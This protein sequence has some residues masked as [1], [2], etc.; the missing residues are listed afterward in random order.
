MTTAT[1]SRLGQINQAGDV[2]AMFLKVF[3]GEVLTAFEQKNIMMGRHQVRTITHGKSASFP[4]TGR[5]TARYHTPGEQVLGTKMSH[6]E[7]IITIDDLLLA[8]SFIA[9][10]DEA[11]NHYEVRSIY[12]GEMGNALANQMDKHI[13][14]VAILAARAANKIT[15]LPGGSI[16]GTNFSGAP[17]AANYATNGEHLAEALFLAAQTLDE[18]DVPED[19]RFCVVRPA[20]YYKLVTAVKN[21]NKDWGG[22]GT[23]SDGNITKIAGIEIVKS[24]NLPNG[25]VAN[26]TTAA[27]TDNKYAGSFSNVVGLVM[28]S[29]AVGTVKLMDLGME[30]E[31]MVSRQGTLMVAKYAV[32]HGVLRPEAAI[33]IRNASVT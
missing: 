29:S 20:Q 10:I 9:N 30:S 25:V 24:N 14:Q 28:H 12:S 32:G 11:M 19:G 17:A 1:V 18:K 21:I 2:K 26:G 27:G 33:E 13:L 16:I 8:D 15:G 23:Y 7:T 4:H 31:Y 22:A 3:A 6:A 5:T